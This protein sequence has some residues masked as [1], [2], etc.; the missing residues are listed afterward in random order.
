ME[1]PPPAVSILIA[2]HNERDCIGETLASIDSQQDVEIEVIV[3]SDGSTDG[4]EE[5]LELRRDITLLRLAKVGK[6]AAL[7]A[8][9]KVAR[10]E[11]VITLDADTRL[12]PDAVARLA[13]AFHDPKVQAAGGW[14][15]V[16]NSDS[17]W[18]T[19]WQFLEYIRNL[20]WRNGLAHL[21]VLLQVSGA[22]GA[23]R[24]ETL[25]RLGG[26]DSS[27]ITEDYEIIY[28]IHRD[29]LERKEE[30]RVVT[31][32][33]AIAHTEAP[34]RLQSFVAQRERWFAGFLRTL[35]GYRF[36][37]GNPTYGPLGFLMLPIKVLDALLP[38][39]A[40]LTWSALVAV[41]LLPHES[42]HVGPID[43]GWIALAFVTKWV[44]DIAMSIL[45]WHWHHEATGSTGA[46][47]STEV[48]QMSKLPP[49]WMA[50]LSESWFFSWF[51]QLAVLG[52]YSRA[53]R[54]P[55]R[56]KGR[57]SLPAKE[58]QD[59]FCSGD[60]RISL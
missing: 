21:G 3:A 39:Y 60:P 50:I 10:H 41:L 5:M 20:L 38:L 22:F 15:F 35:W 29:F 40:L 59:F 45:A 43:G 14:I 56:E 54:K 51:R 24:R 27:S 9:L 48:G 53:F 11:V 1:S 6:A 37:V 33:D 26:F 32:S 17:G 31:C 18:L 57:W 16:R 44:F 13:R 4:M 2:A 30:C 49:P 55:D 23:F 42:T 12:E 34:V 25:L 58:E 36:M 19:Q 52:S 7:N 46:T 47:G 28:R 8:A